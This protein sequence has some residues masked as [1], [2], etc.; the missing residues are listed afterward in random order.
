MQLMAIPS[1]RVALLSMRTCFKPGETRRTAR[2]VKGWGDPCRRPTTRPP[3]APE[4]GPCNR[5]LGFPAP[6][7]E[8]DA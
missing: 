6:E 3:R 7:D 4:S 2:E 5:T 8:G 1:T